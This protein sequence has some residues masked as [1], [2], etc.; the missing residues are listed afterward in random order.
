MIPSKHFNLQ[1]SL[2]AIRKPVHVRPNYRLRKENTKLL[3]IS[4]MRVL[5]P[6]SHHEARISFVRGSLAREG[7]DLVVVSVR[8]GK[9]S[10]SS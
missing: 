4:T 8:A 6:I 9:R 3:P 5:Y 10:L 1:I 7:C 2:E